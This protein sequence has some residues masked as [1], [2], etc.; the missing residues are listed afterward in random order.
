MLWVGGF[1]CVCVCVCVCVEYISIYIYI[2]YINI[3]ICMYV[4]IY[5]YIYICIYIIPGESKFTLVVSLNEAPDLIGVCALHPPRAQIQEIL[6]D[7]GG[8]VFS[9]AEDIRLGHLLRRYLVHLD[10]GTEGDESHAGVFWDE[11]ERHEQ[12]VL[13]RLQLLLLDR[14]VDHEEEERRVCVRTLQLI[15]DR[16]ELNV[17]VG[18]RGGGEGRGMNAS[19]ISTCGL[20]FSV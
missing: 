19:Q 4:Y 9:A 13:E 5:M 11:I 18:G 1:V 12:R 6:D 10:G 8:D 20:G 17:C 16:C 7:L 2:V 15:L 14:R 3:Y